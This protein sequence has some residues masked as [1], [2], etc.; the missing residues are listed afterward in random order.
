MSSMEDSDDATADCNLPKDIIVDILCRL[1]VRS[2]LRFRCVCK[3]WRTLIANPSFIAKHFNQAI[4]CN[5]QLVV[6]TK[7]SFEVKHAVTMIVRT[8]KKR[9]DRLNVELPPPCDISNYVRLV[10]SSNGLLCISLCSTASVILLWNP[11]TREFRNLPERQILVPTGKRVHTVFLGFG[12]EPNSSDYKIVRFLSYKVLKSNVPKVGVVEVYSQITDMWKEVNAGLKCQVNEYSP[13][14]V[15]SGAVHWLGSRVAKEKD[16]IDGKDVIVSFDLGNE[17]FGDL[18]LPESNV[19]AQGH[20]F[21]I[22]VL[23]E[24]LSVLVFPTSGNMSKSIDIWVMKEYGVAAS[25]AK[26]FSIRLFTGVSRPVGC[27]KNGELIL[28][29]NKEKLFLY[30]PRTKKFGTLPLCSARYVYDV[31]SYA[32]SLVAVRAAI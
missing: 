32:E 8:N 11:A 22:C 24:S 9:N 5:E 29:N 13:T 27:F 17:V 2:L 30:N 21:Q 31:H 10:G 3:S 20:G 23:E 7:R 1:P 28:Q 19:Y 15:V 25:W 6:H 12:F 14:A 26:Q 16:S 4:T 18:P